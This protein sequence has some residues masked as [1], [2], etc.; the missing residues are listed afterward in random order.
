MPLDINRLKTS[1]LLELL[2]PNEDGT[3]I[4]PHVV[5]AI[6]ELLL[7]RV[8]GYTVTEDL[9]TQDSYEGVP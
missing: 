5:V 8:K 9:L 3:M 2:L 7:T 1:L 6:V 4:K